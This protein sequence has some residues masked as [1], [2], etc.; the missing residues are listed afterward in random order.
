MYWNTRARS[1]RLILR[2]LITV[3]LAFVLP[4]AAILGLGQPSPARAAPPPKLLHLGQLQ[5]Y[6]TED[7]SEDEPYLVVAGRK[8]WSGVV[9]YGHVAT[10][11][12]VS[13]SHIEPIPFYDN[14]EVVLKEEDGP[15]DG[16]DFLGRNY[17]AASEA[18]GRTHEV[19]FREDGASY[20]LVYALWTAATSFIC[21]GEP[22]VYLYEHTNYR[23]NCTRFVQ[24]SP[25][26]AWSK[27]GNDRASSVRVIGCFTAYLYEHRG[28][29]GDWSA[30]S[31]DDQRLGD[32]RVGNDRVTSVEIVSC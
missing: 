30:F 13:L 26:I 10:V 8:V 28:Y 20:K 14:I 2:W 18:E 24:S 21:D 17:I 16:D 25:H 7:A 15:F 4:L 5:V 12:T 1:H 19:W 22:G 3:L 31:T 9:T 11:V 29:R 6:G 23:G 32:D 27:V